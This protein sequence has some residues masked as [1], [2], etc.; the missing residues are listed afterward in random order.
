[1]DEPLELNLKHIPDK[2]KQFCVRK[3]KQKKGGLGL[4][5]TLCIL[6]SP[7]TQVTGSLPL[8]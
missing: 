6:G 2:L 4:G 1:M 7:M 3:M 8:T 5:G